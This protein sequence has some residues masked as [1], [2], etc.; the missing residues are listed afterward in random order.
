MTYPDNFENK[1][2]FDK[3]RQLITSNCLSDMGRVLVNDIIFSSDFEW[4][5]QSLEET[6]EFMHIC[7][8]EDSFPVSYYQDAR[9]FL[10]R[11][12]VEGLFLEINELIIRRERGSRIGTYIAAIRPFAGKPIF[13]PRWDL[14]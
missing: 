13:L 8:E 3:I 2:K 5:K 11:V 10:A 12:R 9:P 6:T 4:I 7:T 1:I 14:K